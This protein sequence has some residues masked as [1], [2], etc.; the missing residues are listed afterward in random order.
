MHQSMSCQVNLWLWF[1]SRIYI[2]DVYIHAYMHA[3]LWRARWP[4]TWHKEWNY[5]EWRL[6]ILKMLLSPLTTQWLDRRTGIAIASRHFPDKNPSGE[7]AQGGRNASA[8][9]SQWL[10]EA[11]VLEADFQ[12]KTTNNG[13]NNAYIM[14]ISKLKLKIDDFNFVSFILKCLLL[15]LWLVCKSIHFYSCLDTTASQYQNSKT[16][17]LSLTAEMFIWW[18]VRGAD[19]QRTYGCKRSVGIKMNE[20]DEW[21]LDRAADVAFVSGMVKCWQYTSN[22]FVNFVFICM[23]SA[24]LND[25]ILYSKA[26]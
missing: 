17:P 25:H 14:F 9:Q 6:S 4:F 2:Q 20:K 23:N 8:W 16:E 7:A 11:D 19:H 15:W 1:R 22:A 10:V 18:I 12:G 26:F 21:T 13:R 24:E 3:Y 5:I